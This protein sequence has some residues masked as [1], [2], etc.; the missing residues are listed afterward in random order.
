MKNIT[1][2]FL[3]L[4][5]F[6]CNQIDSSNFSGL[7][8]ND[9]SGISFSEQQLQDYIKL[10]NQLKTA[11]PT[12]LEKLNEAEEDITQSGEYANFEK[13]IQDAGMAYPDFVNLNAK[14]GTIYSF[15]EI[16]AGTF[17]EINDMQQ[18]Q[19]QSTIDDIQ[20]MLDDPETPESA[21]PQLRQS[22]EQAKKGKVGFQDMYANNQEKMEG[23]IKRAQDKLR[24]LAS[25]EEIALVNK[26]QK[27][28]KS[29]FDG[30]FRPGRRE[31]QTF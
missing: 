19:L 24:S 5:C 8:G 2:L 30:L 20:K 31:T 14:V 21:K 15:S 16:N 27:E 9:G 22:L 1:I 10:Y 28:L 12:T 13:M 18:E 29:A 4:I 3:C 26:Y 11:A 7:G 6:A 25:E 17:K 23:Q